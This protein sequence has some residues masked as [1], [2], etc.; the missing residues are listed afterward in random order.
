[1]R[2][3]TLLLVICLVGLTWPSPASSQL[4]REH[5]GK[6]LRAFHGLPL[7]ITRSFQ[8]DKEAH[9]VFKEILAISGLSGMEDRII[10]RASAETN[11]AEAFVEQTAD[12]QG[13]VKEERLIFYNAEFMQNLARKTKRSW[14]MVAI[15]AHEVGHHLR[16]HTVIDG[17]NHE[18]ELEADYQAGFILRRMGATLDETQAAFREIGTDSATPSHPARA[19]RVQAATLGWTDGGSGTSPVSSSSPY[20]PPQEQ[21]K[22]DVT[23]RPPAV[24]C[25]WYAIAYCTQDVGIAHTKTGAYGGFVINTGHYAKFNPGWFCVAQGPMDKD[26]ANAL[27]LRMKASG[28]STAYIKNSC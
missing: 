27:M 9:A 21:P 13:N 23:L 20:S 6:A 4:V 5:D 11:N 2:Q 10:I 14:S 17:R 19:Q 24:T 22:M 8:S 18:F 12:K 16:F 15:L 1:M 26:S 28:A 7:R 3:S 25:G